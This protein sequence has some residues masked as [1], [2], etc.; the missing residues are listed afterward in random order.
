VPH[1]PPVVSQVIRVTVSESIAGLAQTPSPSTGRQPAPPD[2]AVYF[3]YPRDGALI[4]PKSTIRFGLRNMGVAPAGVNKPNTGHHH[5]VVD[6]DT[7]ALDVPLPNDPNHIHF[8]GG[9]TEVKLNLPP[10]EHTL[11]LILADDRHI[12]HDP[13]VMSPKIKVIAGYP[14][15]ARAR[16][17]VRVSKSGRVRR[18]SRSNARARGQ[19]Y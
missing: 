18:R 14:K 3:V 1:D 5:L 6:A 4:Y 2:A 13:P 16:P 11:Q 19:G 7:P 12:P 17:A 9:Q 10:G 8:G 15:P